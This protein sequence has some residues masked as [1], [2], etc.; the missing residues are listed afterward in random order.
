MCQS[1]RQNIKVAC[2]TITL[3]TC[4]D[5]M[6]GWDLGIPILCTIIP[7]SMQRHAHVHS[8]SNCAVDYPSAHGEALS[9]NFRAYSS[10]YLFLL[11]SETK[12]FLED[13]KGSFRSNWLLSDTVV[14]R[15]PRW[16]Q[17]N[18]YKREN[19]V[20]IKFDVKLWKQSVNREGEIQKESNQ[21]SALA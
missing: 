21:C 20:F 13:D 5:K 10:L 8:P 7:V 17:A 9:W 11:C 3:Q 12:E 1:A 14:W 16:N 15:F 19:Y 18:D 2:F 6:S 4:H